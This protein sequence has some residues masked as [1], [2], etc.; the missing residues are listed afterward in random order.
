MVNVAGNAALIAAAQQQA[1]SEKALIDQ[2]RKAEATNVRA[3]RSLDL[4]AKGADKVLEGLIKRGHVREAGGG[5]YWLDDEAI[6]R[7]KAAGVRFSL[8]L[9]AFLLSA[10]ASLL[11]LALAF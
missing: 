7:G 2:L 5:T 11:A 6:A 10:T 3:A 9:I 4:S 8:I 1:L